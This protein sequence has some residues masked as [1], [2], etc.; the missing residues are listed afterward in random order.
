[1]RSNYWRVLTGLFLI[2]VLFFGMTVPADAD[3]ASDLRRAQEEQRRTQRQMQEIQRRKSETENRQRRLAEE[4]RQAEDRLYQVRNDLASLEVQLAETEQQTRA[5]VE[6][7]RRAEDK[8]EQRGRLLNTRVRVI[9]EMGTVSL[10]QVLMDSTDFRDFV[11][12]FDLLK[13]IVTKD[14]EL[15]NQVRLIRDEINAKKTQ[16]EDRRARIA[17]FKSQSEAKRQ[18][19]QQVVNVVWD[20]KQET[21]RDLDLLERQED[22]LQSISKELESRIF[23]L[24]RQMSFKRVGRLAFQWP[25]RGPIS[26]PFGMRWHPILNKYKGHN[27]LDI[28]APTGRNILSAESGSVIHSG[29][30]EGYGYAVIIDHGDG[31]ATLYAHAS[32]L[33]VSQGQTVDR[34]MPVALVG[35]TGWSTG[36]H[37]HFEVRVKGVPQNPIEWLP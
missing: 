30:I 11:T 12:R 7:L 31:V 8:L 6:E 34:G 15:F 27:G 29:W 5:T 24:Q 10:L 18:E 22:Q 9:H 36:P 35:S 4:L 2:G 37:L 17:S 14:V 23:D 28:A 1:M 33:L 32:R 26:S 21:L 20:K 16:L 3:P 19:V 25:V 13:N